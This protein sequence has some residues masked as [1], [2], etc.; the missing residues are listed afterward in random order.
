MRYILGLCCLSNLHRVRF[1]SV[2]QM[3]KGNLSHSGV[4]F[5]SALAHHFFPVT[6][7]LHAH[8][9]LAEVASSS[10][11]SGSRRAQDIDHAAAETRSAEN[12]VLGT[13]RPGP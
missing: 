4:L 13:A 8:T 2:E 9:H 10:R 7:A 1:V 3:A 6:R 5:K 11:P 12:T